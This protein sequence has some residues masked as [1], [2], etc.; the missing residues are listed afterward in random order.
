L[1]YQ[2]ENL[3]IVIVVTFAKIYLQLKFL[4]LLKLDQN[5]TIKDKNRTTNF[6]SVLVIILQN[7]IYFS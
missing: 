6:A 2:I 7:N 5:F 4:T 1:N 3:N